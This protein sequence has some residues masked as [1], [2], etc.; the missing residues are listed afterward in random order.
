MTTAEKDALYELMEAAKRKQKFDSDYELFQAL[1]FERPS[2]GYTVKNGKNG[3]STEKMLKLMKMA[4]KLVVMLAISGALLHPA[5]E[6]QAGT[7][8]SMSMY[9]VK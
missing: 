6:A 7:D 5:T 2:S 3:L 8:R 4:G 1:G 9:Y